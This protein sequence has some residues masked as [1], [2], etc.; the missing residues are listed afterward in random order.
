MLIRG[1]PD[2]Y[3]SLTVYFLTPKERSN[4]LSRIFPSLIA[5]SPFRC[6]WWRCCCWRSRGCC[7][8]WKR[9]QFSSPIAKLNLFFSLARFFACA[10]KAKASKVIRKKKPSK[11]WGREKTLLEKEDICMTIQI[12][13]HGEDKNA[14]Q[15]VATARTKPWR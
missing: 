5:P 12:C 3:I 14:P 10:N 7:G 9:R 11:G 4:F 8:C 2:S 13:V 6:C 1:R 15:K